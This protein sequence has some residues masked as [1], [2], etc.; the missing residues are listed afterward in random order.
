MPDDQKFIDAI[1]KV[2]ADKGADYQY[3]NTEC[4]YQT[5]GPT[6][7]STVHC[8]IG[9]A[10]IEAGH[11]YRGSWEYCSADELTKNFGYSNEVAVAARKAQI[12][13]DTRNSWGDAL[14]AFDRTHGEMTNGV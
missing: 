2:V 14:E 13:Q 6:E 1:H 11:D 7:E 3:P 10:L 8:L 12:Q 5:V 9:A 4:R